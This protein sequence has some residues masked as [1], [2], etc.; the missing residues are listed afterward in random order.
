M[1]KLNKN[2][3]LFIMAVSLILIALWSYAVINRNL[4]YKNADLFAGAELRMLE[5]AQSN[6]SIPA[7][8]KTD[9]KT[10]QTKNFSDTLTRNPFTPVYLNRADV[11]SSQNFTDSGNLISAPASLKLS[12]II[13]INNV[14]YAIINDNIAKEG[15]KLY[16]MAIYKISDNQV[17]VIQNDQ[18]YYINMEKANLKK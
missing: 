10:F 17:T 16:G 7:N 14:K 15:D 9:V 2:E 11:I 6:I 3:R 5:A 18:L 13:L 1:K 12:G 8:S 4:Q